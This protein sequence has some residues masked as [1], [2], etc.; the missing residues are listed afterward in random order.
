MPRARSNKL[1]G[2]AKMSISVGHS[3]TP[4]QRSTAST[5]PHALL[6]STP[7][8]CNCTDTP[9][10]MRP[11]RIRRWLWLCPLG[12]TWVHARVKKNAC[13]IAPVAD[14]CINCIGGLVLGMQL[15]VSRDP[16]SDGL[17]PALCSAREMTCVRERARVGGVCQC[18]S[19][20]HASTSVQY[21]EF[22][23]RERIE[24]GSCTQIHPLTTL[25]E[26][27]CGGW[28][29]AGGWPIKAQQHHLF[30]AT[31]LHENQPTL[32]PGRDGVLQA[33]VV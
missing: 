31:W 11:H 33:H 8:S 32:C 27:V 16:R 24:R 6:S 20:A 19:M 15:T 28:C 12:S 10:P 18:E 29:S 25:W 26:V 30:E 9:S 22:T 3:N 2:T 4:L 21:F 23:K 13:S 17:Q 7:H 5:P 14:I 1:H